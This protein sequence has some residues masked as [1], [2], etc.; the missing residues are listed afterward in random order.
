MNLNFSMRDDTMNLSAE[1]P[2]RQSTPLP[3]GVRGIRTRRRGA[4]PEGG[5]D[6]HASDAPLLRDANPAA[7]Y[8]LSS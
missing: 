2:T 4:E 6:I 7:S 3:I 8:D 5:S 1:H